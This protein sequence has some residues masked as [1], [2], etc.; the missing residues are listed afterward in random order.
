MQAGDDAPASGG[1]IHLI[2]DEKA[3]Q[4]GGWQATSLKVDAM[5]NLV[6]AAEQIA[7]R[8]F[9]P[10][11][12]LRH[13]SNFRSDANYPAPRGL[14]HW[15]WL[16]AASLLIVAGAF[17]WRAVSLQ[18]AVASIHREQSELY[19]AAFPGER[20]P[21]AL[22]ARLRSEYSK[23]LGSRQLKSSLDIP[24]HALPIL[25]DVLEHLPSQ[26]NISLVE[27]SVNDAELTMDVEVEA[28]QLAGEIVKQLEQSGLEV[29]PP[30]ISSARD[31]RVRA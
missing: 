3:A 28:Y 5:G 18:R 20:V 8:S 6:R 1:L 26:R 4:L 22:M 19:R 11:F 16:L 7:V 27:L 21:S 17:A 25:Q 9:E 29:D 23:L 15:L 24:E 12:N 14:E 30:S 13:D 31:E 10:W 2:A